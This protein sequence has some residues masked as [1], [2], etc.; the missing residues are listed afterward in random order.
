ERRGVGGSVRLATAQLVVANHDP[1]VAQVLERLEVI[2]REPRAAVQQH[3]GCPL[4][5]AGYLVP[6]VATRYRE[7]PF[8]Q[9]NRRTRSTLTTPGHYHDCKGE[10]SSHGLLRWAVCTEPW[11]PPWMITNRAAIAYTSNVAGNSPR[12]A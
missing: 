6:D 8:S 4:P 1:L 10:P 7:A 9:W 11:T 12:N 5:G 3:Q 2:T